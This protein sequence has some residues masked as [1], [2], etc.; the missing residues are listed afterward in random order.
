M[1]FSLA[2]RVEHWAEH[3]RQFFYAVMLAEKACPDCGGWL[4]MVKEG[5]CRCEGCGNTLDPTVTFQQCAVCGGELMLSVR[6]YRCRQCGTDV[7]SRFLF[8][9]L[10][11]D[12]EY[13]RQRMQENRQRQKELRDRVREM[14]AQHRSLPLGPMGA[15][16]AQM[17]ELFDALNGLT[18]DLSAEDWAWPGRGID[19]SRYEAHL[20]AHIGPIT[21]GF[22]QLP[23]LSENPR[24]DRIWRFVALI[25]MAQAGI[26]DLAQEGA[27]ILV[28]QH[29]PDAEGS[30]IPGEAEATA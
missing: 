28:K 13:F 11:F 21:V 25:F 16:P 6:R 12:A 7:P 27:N 14:L 1:A 18:A 9:G 4:M 22:D 29:D 15:D 19:L 26:V 2:A 3:A 20:Q 17:S 5:R 23:P 10:V 8:D 24:Q 30:G